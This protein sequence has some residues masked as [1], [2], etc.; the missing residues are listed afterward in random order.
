MTARNNFLYL[1]RMNHHIDVEW[2][3]RRAV[4]MMNWCRDNVIPV[5]NWYYYDENGLDRTRYVGTKRFEGD[6]WADYDDHE[7]LCSQFLVRDRD[8][9]LWRL[10][11]A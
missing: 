5:V 10:R 8:Y 7:V 3:I 6:M 9:E 4:G 11:F 1:D 2:P